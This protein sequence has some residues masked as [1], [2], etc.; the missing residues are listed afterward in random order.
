VTDAPVTVLVLGAAGQ[1]GSE[2]LSISRPGLRVVGRDVSEVDVTEPSGVRRSLSEESPAVVINLAAWTDVDG[3][4]THEE[5]AF[6]VNRDGAGIV[7]AACSAAGASFVHLSTDYVF[8]GDASRPYAE[9]DSARPL[10][11]YG[12]S[13]LAGEERVVE[14]HPDA[15]ILRTS[16]IFG[17]HGSNFVKAILAAARERDELRV[18]DDQR[19]C[20]TA[21]PDLAAMLLALAARLAQRRNPTD[22]AESSLSRPRGLLH[23]TNAGDA[24]W[25]E[26]ATAAVEAARGHLPLRVETIRP[27][28][29]EAYGAPALRP[30]YTVLD[31]SKAERLGFRRPSWRDG[32][33]RVLEDLGVN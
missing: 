14:E 24:S 20:P 2:L 17:A 28:T 27:I 7:A 1:V 4:E 33:R 16:A 30:R 25:H 12:A 6:R 11:V 5:A 32:L 18:V 19:S 23:W 10:N 15:V 31:C 21:A 9:T 29:T 26:L 13:K 3:A 8:P 22:D